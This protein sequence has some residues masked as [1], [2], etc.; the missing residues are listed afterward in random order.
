VTQAREALQ[1]LRDGAL[2]LSVK[3]GTPSTTEQHSTAH[4]VEAIPAQQGAPDSPRVQ[5]E[6]PGTNSLGVTEN[7]TGTT[8]SPDTLLVAAPDNASSGES[9]SQ[10]PTMSSVD[11]E[12]GSLISSPPVPIDTL[13]VQAGNE[14]SSPDGSG[15][16]SPEPVIWIKVQGAFTKL[17][18]TTLPPLLSMCSGTH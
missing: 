14:V 10:S 11:P 12:N 17:K 4:T 16:S 3:P 5:Q 9:G 8:A 6:D 15:H 13:S 18:G 7:T 1:R 2:G